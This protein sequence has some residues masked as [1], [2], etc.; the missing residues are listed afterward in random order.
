M[1]YDKVEFMKGSDFVP[2]S[3]LHN[4]TVYSYDG[5]NTPEEIIKNALANGIERVGISDHQFSLGNGFLAYATEITALKKKYSGKIEVL[6]GLEIGTRPAPNDFIMSHSNM[7]DYCLFE[8]LDSPVAMDLYEFM[9]WVRLFRCP[10]GLAHTDIFALG[11]RYGV[12]MVKLMKEHG[13]FWE[14]NTS[15]NYSYYYDFLTNPEKRA[16][17]AES[18]ITLSVGSDTHW[19]GDYDA[20]KLVAANELIERLGN[21][22]IF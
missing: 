8:S 11:K 10:V 9:E 2:I 17:V 19:V 3:D 20:R 14:I 1:C 16:L 5:R 12:D 13:I 15:G 7:L 6:L 21:P 22:K 4:H 18:G